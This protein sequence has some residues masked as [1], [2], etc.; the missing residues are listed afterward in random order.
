MIRMQICNL[1]VAGW[2]GRH[3]SA[4]ETTAQRKC[5]GQCVGAGVLG[6]RGVMRSNKT[7]WFIKA[8]LWK[9]QARMSGEK[10]SGQIQMQKQGWGV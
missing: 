2:G 7:G 8:L 1:A 9:R 3:F 4:H 10:H 5:R 6:I